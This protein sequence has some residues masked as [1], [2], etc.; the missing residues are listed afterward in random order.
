MGIYTADPQNPDGDISLVPAG[1][2]RRCP[3]P[4]SGAL[5]GGPALVK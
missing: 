4:A 3:G 1:D 2:Q 5:A